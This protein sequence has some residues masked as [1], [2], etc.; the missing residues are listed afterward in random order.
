MFE[1]QGLPQPEQRPEMKVEIYPE[2]QDFV[3][4]E[5]TQDPFGYFE[6]RG[7]N[8]KPGD[9]EYDTTGRIK[10]DPTAVKDLPVWQNPGGV[11]L[12]A[13]AKKVNTKKGVFKKGAHPFHEVTVMD[14]VRKRGLPAPAPVARVQRGGEFLVVMERAKG[15]TTFDA[16]LQI[17]F[18][19]WQYSELDK[20][21]LK[22]DAE[23]AMAELRE[24]FEQAGIKRKWKLTDMVF[25]VDFENRKV[26]G[27]VPV[28]WERTEITSQP[29]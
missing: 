27:I 15:L 19:T 5:F 18:Q 25:E 8:I 9:T 17:A 1:T 26:V 14:E 12:K 20:Q 3:P 2:F 28:D 11:E 16:A 6:T 4:A 21:V 7:K 10:E 22:Q 13:V 29:V 24:R 23:R